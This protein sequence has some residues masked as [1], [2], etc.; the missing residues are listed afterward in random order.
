VL[1]LPLLLLL[2]LLL[3]PTLFLHTPVKHRARLAAIDLMCWSQL[4]DANLALTTK[5]GVSAAAAAAAA[6]QAGKLLS[7]VGSQSLD[8]LELP[9]PLP[10]IDNATK[11][12]LAAAAA[13]T[14][15]GKVLSQV[16]SQSLD[17]LELVG[18]ISL[19]T[20]G[21]I[22]FGYDAFECTDL[23]KP[24]DFWRVRGLACFGKQRNM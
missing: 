24:C 23:T 4:A 1:G 3:L 2:L 16:G 20:T 18:R 11:S 15:A 5:F 21:R 12:A 22:M 17:M 6:M 10:G 7:Q 13:A 8:V 19:S 9:L 14:Q